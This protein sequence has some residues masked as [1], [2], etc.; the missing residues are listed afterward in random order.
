M[1]TE[2]PSSLHTMG[3]QHGRR[4]WAE[5]WKIK[6]VEP[7]KMTTREER[8]RGARRGR[9]QHLPPAVGRRLHRPA[10]RLRHE[11]DE[12]P[13][14]GRDDAGRRGLRGQ[15]QLLPPRGR[16]PAVLRLH[17]HR[18][19]PPGPRRG[20]PDQPDADQGRATTSP[21]TCTSRPPASTRS[22]R[23]RT[24]DDVIIDE[25]HDPQDQHPF[26]GNVD[27]AKV[28]ALIDEVGADRIPYVSASPAPSTWP[29]AS[30][31]R[32][33]TSASSGRCATPTASG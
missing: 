26:K 25:A 1:T 11:R 13:A 9:L 32:W 17:V 14:V 21:A 12:R 23:A 4:S 15:P 7:L 27:L 30:R 29:A 16:R 18:P 6:M 22:W 10:D 33:P 3:Q 20:A 2:R 19:D 31:C 5:P 8:G 28:Q 24:F